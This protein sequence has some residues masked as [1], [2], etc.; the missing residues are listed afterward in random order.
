MLNDIKVYIAQIKN[1]IELL[2]PIEEMEGIMSEI[3][4][5]I[6][7]NWVDEGDYKLNRKQLFSLVRK[8]IAKKY[9]PN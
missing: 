9:N 1:R 2:V 5:I 4:E 6:L 8:Y 7:K 3:S